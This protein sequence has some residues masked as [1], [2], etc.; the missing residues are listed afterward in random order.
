MQLIIHVWSTSKVKLNYRDLL[1]LVLTV[2]KTNQDN[3]VID[4]IGAVCTENE[5]ELLWLI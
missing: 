2:T 3:D 1:D 5:I 4:C